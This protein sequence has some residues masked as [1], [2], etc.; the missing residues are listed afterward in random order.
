ERVHGF[1]PLGLNDLGLRGFKS[2]VGLL[3]IGKRFAKKF[4]GRLA[5]SNITGYHDNAWRTGLVLDNVALRFNETNAAIFQNQPVIGARSHVRQNRVAE[6]FY[7]AIA[8]G[9][10]NFLEGISADEEF[11]VTEKLFVGRAVV[12]T[13]PFGIDHSDQ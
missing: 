13:T 4:G 10:M 12:H 9:R 2:F 1:V 3:E 5:F 8:I 7:N 11:R 6:N